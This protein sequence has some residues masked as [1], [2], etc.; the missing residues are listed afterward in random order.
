MLITGDDSQGVLTQFFVGPS[1]WLSDHV[2]QP[3]H[4]PLP[5]SDASVDCGWGSVV[6]V[7]RKTGEHTG[8]IW[9]I[10]GDFIPDFGDLVHGLAGGRD[11]PGCG[12]FG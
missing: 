4:I 6:C 10:S 8:A 1:L 11:G 9:V 3:R 2:E 5:D 7:C 12:H